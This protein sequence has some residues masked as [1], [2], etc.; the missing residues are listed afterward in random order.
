MV[1]QPPIVP[2]RRL[3]RFGFHHHTELF[4]GRFAMLG[5]MALLPVEWK[6][7]HGLLVWP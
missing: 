4:N 1:L 3:P 6:L 5:F 7:G 2:K